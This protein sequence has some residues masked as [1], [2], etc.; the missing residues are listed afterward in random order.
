MIAMPMA[1]CVKEE[2]T[3][4]AVWR[5]SEVLLKK[6]FSREYVKGVIA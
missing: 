1:C 6:E 3:P 5:Y 4:G 2:L